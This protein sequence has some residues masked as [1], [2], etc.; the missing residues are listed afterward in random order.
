MRRA[1]AGLVAVLVALALA[2]PGADSHGRAADPHGTFPRPARV[3]LLVLENR[4]YEQVIGSPRAPYLNRLARTGALETRAY[5]L[6]H[7]SLPNYIALTGGST[8]AIRH[9]CSSCQTRAPNLVDQL[10]QAGISWRGYFQGIPSTGSLAIRRGDYSAHYNPFTYY[11][12]TRSRDVTQDRIVSFTQL[13]QDL[14]AGALPRFSWIAP[15]LAHDGHNRSLRTTDR[16]ARVLVPRV[17]HALGRRG[18]LYVTWDEG[19]RS[20]T[21]GLHGHGGGR[22]A[23]IAAGPLARRHA[24]SRTPVDQYALLRSLEAGFGLDALGHAGDASTPLLTGLVHGH[25]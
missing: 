2:A 20:D 23:L 10:N 13:H 4:S 7:P 24:A 12:R 11:A 25:A 1:L 8:H 15:D 18:L 17:L 9:D 22:V 6:A 5:A 14:A 19:R 3:A 21:R 16:Y